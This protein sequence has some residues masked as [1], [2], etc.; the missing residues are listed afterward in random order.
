MAVQ[1]QHQTMRSGWLSYTLIDE[2]PLI[3]I[4]RLDH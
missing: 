4:A 1:C 3:R 2:A